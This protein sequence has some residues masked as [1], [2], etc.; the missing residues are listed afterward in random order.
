[1][2]LKV[3]RKKGSL[4]TKKRN[5]GNLKISILISIGETLSKFC[6]FSRVEMTS[7]VIAVY[8]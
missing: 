1:M 8:L 7:F 2:Y 6:I 5:K 3:C 4:V